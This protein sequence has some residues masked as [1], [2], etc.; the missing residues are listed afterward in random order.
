MSAAERWLAFDKV[1]I[2]DESG[3]TTL[4]DADGFG[5]LGLG[6]RVRYILEKRLRFY[7]GSREVP[8]KVALASLQ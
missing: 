7:S 6:L 1:E 3:R 5:A 4:L 2:T 8:V